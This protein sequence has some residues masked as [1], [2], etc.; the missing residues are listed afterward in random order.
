MPTSPRGGGWRLRAPSP[1]SEFDD[2]K[3]TPGRFT[4]RQPG[5]PLTETR[6]TPRM[7]LTVDEPARG[8]LGEMDSASAYVSRLVEDAERRWRACLTHLRASGWADRE[9]LAVCDALNGYGLTEYSGIF[10]AVAVA[11][12]LHDAE[13]LNGTAAKWDVAPERWAVLV[14]QVS[15]SETVARALIDVAAEFWRSN[16]R[17]ERALNWPPKETP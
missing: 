8:I 17:L 10:P 6:K 7:N 15:E 4:A 14:R 16:R 11:L 2:D 12:E 9:V 5:D 1:S 3:T 13:R